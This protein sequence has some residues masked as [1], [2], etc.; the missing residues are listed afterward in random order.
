MPTF[1]G[2]SGD[3][4]LVGTNDDDEL[5]LRGG[6]DFGDGGG[7]NDI[8]R[9]G[10]GEDRL[11]GGAGNDRLFGG[12][13]ND[14]LFGGAGD[15]VLREEVVLSD[16]NANTLFGGAGRDSLIAGGFDD[17]LF[18]G[19]GNDLF[20]VDSLLG[21]NSFVMVSFLDGAGNGVVVD[22]AAGTATRGAQVD[23]L[24]DISDIIGTSGDDVIRGQD[25]EDQYGMLIGHSFFGLDG[26]DALVGAFGP[27][28]LF[29]GQ[30][31]DFLN[32]VGQSSFVS[33]RLFGGAGDDVLVNTQVASGGAG[34]D[35]ITS[36]GIEGAA[37]TSGGDGNDVIRISGENFG[38]FGDAGNDRLIV[39]DGF[40]GSLQGGSGDDVLISFITGAA[41]EDEEALTLQGDAGRDICIGDTPT[42]RFRFAEGDTV[43]GSR[44]DVIVNFN[45][46][47]TDPGSF[48][49]GDSI[50]VA[51]IDAHIGQPGDQAF[52]FA[53]ETA[54]PAAGSLG[55]Y[56]SGGGTIIV[57][58]TGA[59]IFEIELDAYT[60]PVLA[61]Y[62]VL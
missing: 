2:T 39:T 28:L 58:D 57:A 19:G 1:I 9:G 15:D 49:S 61:E 6:D 22:L 51:A 37:Q 10:N 62:F 33:D 60:G 40:E 21:P 47:D 46:V 35:V 38:A 52:V 56:R 7:G 41:S 32:G 14:E 31:N 4:S 8:V 20:R 27:D 3:N 23:R 59:V 44:R 43:A 50:D 18:G 24:F 13:Q 30:G 45:P 26:D 17:V 42:E 53:G 36:R 25:V 54:D 5:L 11:F 48:D 16:A 29:G 34:N 55:F 12:N